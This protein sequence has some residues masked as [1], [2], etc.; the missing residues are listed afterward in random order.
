MSSLIV[1]Y[2]KWA[3]LGASDSKELQQHTIFRGEINKNKT[4]RNEV[5]KSMSL[6]T[7]GMI[8]SGLLNIIIKYIQILPLHVMNNPNVKLPPKSCNALLYIISTC[9]HMFRYRN[10]T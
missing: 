2:I 7:Y 6:S 3:T 10:A 8:E 9:L 4:I 1:T 5:A